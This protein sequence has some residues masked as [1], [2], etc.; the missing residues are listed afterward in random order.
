MITPNTASFANG[1]T[2]QFTAT[3]TFSDQSTQDLSS[4]V[5]WSSSNAQVLTIATTGLATGGSVGNATISASLNGVSASTG[6]VQV[7]AA[8]LASISISPTTRADCQGQHRSNSQATGLFTDGSTQNLSTNVTWITSNSAVASISASGLA[9]GTGVGSAQLTAVYQTLTASTTSFMVTQAA[10]VSITFNPANPTVAAGTGTQVSVIGTF[11]DGSTQDLTST[12]MFTSSNTAAVTVSSSGV[13]TG[14]APGSSMVSVSVNG[15]TNSFNVTVSSATLTSIV[16]SPSN[17]A[18]IAKGTTEQFTA[19]GMYTDG[20][21]QNL[22]STVTWTSANATIAMVDANGL[23]T[24]TGIGTDQLTAS[25]QGKSTNSANFQ[26]TAA[27]V[28]SITVAPST[29]SVTVGST[30]QFT[31]MATYTDNSTNDVSSMAAWTSNSNAVATVNGNGLATGQSAG[32]A[33]ITATYISHAGTA[34]LTVS[35]PPAVTLS[36]IVITPSSASIAKGN[37]QQFQATGDYS[38]GS[39]QS[40]TALVAWQSSVPSVATINSSGL[41]ASVAGGNTQI[42]A[43]YEGVSAVV[44]LTV[45]PAVL[46]SIAVTPQTTTLADGT[47]QQY[48]AVGTLTDGSTQDLTSSVNWS[49]TNTA[50]ATISTSG[51][52]T[53]LAV[54]HGTGTTTIAA[55]AGSTTATATLNVTAATAVSVQLSPASV[56][57]PAGGT[58]QLLATATFTDGSSQNVTSSVTYTSSNGSIASVNASGDVTGLSVGSA[59]ITA[60]LGSISTSVMVTVS[61][62]VL[63][64]IAVTPANITLAAGVSQQLTATGTFTDGSTQN[65]TNSVAWTSSSS[66]TATVSNTGNLVAATAGSAVISATS[67]SAGNSVSGTMAVTVTSAVITSITVSPG[68]LTLAAGQTQQYT[69][70]A[71]MSDQSQQTVT[72]SAA[73]SVTDPTR[74][75]ISN[76]MG[77]V[78]LLTTTAAGAFN[79][80]ATLNSISGSAPVTVTAAVLS[81]IAI[82]PNPVSLPSGTTQPLTVTGHYSDGSTANVTSSA[83]WTSSAASTATVNSTGVVS[84]NAVGSTTITATVQGSSATDAVTVTS[85]VLESIT[86]IPASVSLALGL[87]QQLTATGTYLGGAT[88]DITSQVQWSSTAPTVAT[89]SN[90]GLVST[91][92]TGSSYVA[93]TLNS[94]TAQIPVT[95]TAAALQSIAV[96]AATPSFGLGFSDQLTAIGTYS[97]SST[98]VLTSSVTWSSLTPGV[99]VVTSAGLATGVSVGSFTARATYGGKTGSLAISVTSA[100]LQT[101]VVTPAN[102][103]LVN[104]LGAQLQFSAIGHYSDGTSVDISTSVHWALSGVVVGSISQTGLYSAVG[105]GLGTITATSGT[106]SGSTGLTVV[107]L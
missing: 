39:T 47:S 10:L 103:V 96:T 35:A 104:A 12:A 83:T 87:H 100:V 89:V 59:S 52:T 76:S 13:V 98:Q 28:A 32:S 49:S 101:I 78:G 54:S 41:A 61:S 58:Q 68:S 38:D 105:V 70:V 66:H 88:A 19:T 60:T 65:L 86:I 26:V 9:T 42:W 51:S 90:G 48:K 84:G 27:V 92:H 64:S 94:I 45:S 102:S 67:T 37:T 73:W 24:G 71:T 55:Q 53:G 22:S 77:S 8:T 36:S 17:P 29:A 3:G 11:S 34:T 1:T 80:K 18:P 31:A 57:L 4:Q 33:T 91:L 14:V 7:T 107:S 23:A 97:D 43:S 72:T 79:V 56:S 46:V 69:A 2:Q 82:T 81:S 106:I 63:S 16:I 93:A 40:L 62:A 50:V 99:G 30:Q 5:V 85:P 75:T 95:V 21:T 74:G 6:R 25:Y 15:V 44:T 20:S